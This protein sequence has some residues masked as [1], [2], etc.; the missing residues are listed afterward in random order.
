M[1]TAFHFIIVEQRAAA[2]AEINDLNFY[3][4]Y[5][6]QSAAQAVLE[7]HPSESHTEIVGLQRLAPIVDP[8]ASNPNAGGV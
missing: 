4:P 8:C 7:G 6:T 5:P 3:G 2:S 1:N